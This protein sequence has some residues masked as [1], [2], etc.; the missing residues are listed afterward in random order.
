VGKYHIKVK[1]AGV[2]IPTTT[3]QTHAVGNA[4]KCKIN[5]EQLK[6]Q[7]V[8]GEEY[9]VTVNAKEAGQGHVNC[10]ITSTST[11]VERHEE[12]RTEKTDKGTKIIKTITTKTTTQTK[13]RSGAA[14]GSASASASAT[15]AADAAGTTSEPAVDV[16]IVENGDGTYTIKYK[17]LESGDYDMVLRFGGQLIPDGATQISVSGK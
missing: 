7:V 15:G 17:V 16:N 2:E 11:R 3:V 4:T 10:R 12:T 14:S 6:K 8:A 9:S 5:A 1:Y 13:T